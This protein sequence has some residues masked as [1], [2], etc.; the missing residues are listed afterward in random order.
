MTD[1]PNSLEDLTDS[2]WKGKLGW[3]P[4]NSS[5]QTMITAMRV[6]WGEDKTRQWLI[7]IQ[8]NEP[9]VYS[10]NTPQVVAAAAEEINIGLVNHYYLHRFIAEQGDS[11]NARNLYLND[12]GP[13]ALVMIAGGGILKTS[14]NKNNAEKFLKFM[15]STVTQQYIAG[16]IYEYPVVEG[17][18]THMF[19]TPLSD[20]NIP[21]INMSDLSDLEGTQ[22]IFRELGILD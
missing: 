12:G 6:M 5:F 14:S 9:L 2:K 15:T 20:L 4:S 13:G 21:T 8:E 16:Q 19:L 11:F 17:V 3:A 22:A 10:K 18:K 7:D 1:L